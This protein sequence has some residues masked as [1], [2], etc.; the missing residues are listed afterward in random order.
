MSDSV[1][2]PARPQS[3]FASFLREPPVALEVIL[4]LLLVAVVVGIRLY[5]WHL[6]PAYMWSRDAGSY[7]FAAFQWLDTG[8]MVFDG[9]RG[10]VYTLLIA[11]ALKLFGTMNGVVWTQHAL[12]GLA[13][14]G[15]VATA[16]YCWGRVAVLPLF[17]C[18]ICLAAYGLPLH[19]GQLIRNESVL[20][21]LS[22]AAFCSWWL[23]L[24]RNSQTWLFI[25]ALSAGILT[26]TKNVFVPFPFALIAGAWFLEGHT[27]RGKIT[28]VILV[29]CGFAL[30]FIALRLD[31]EVSVHVNPPEPQSGI[32]FYGRTAQWTKLDGGIEPELKAKIRAEVEDYKARPKL[33]NNIVIKR[34]I[35]PHLWRE[36]QAQG[37]TAVDLD[38]LCRRLAI[39][40]VK[41]QPKAFWGQ[42]CADTY[43]LNVRG[44]KND[45]PSPEQVRDAIEELHHRDDD[46]RVHP[47]MQVEKNLAALE[48]HE[49]K[50]D[51]RLFHRLL[52]RALLFQ[53]YPVFETT[54]ALCFI[55]LCTR[56]REREFFLGGAAVWFFNMVLLCTV[57]RPIE[58]YLMPLVPVMFWALSGALVLLWRTAL[59]VKAEPVSIS[60]SSE[61]VAEAS[62]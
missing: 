20:F 9:R 50:N 33:D 27:L 16:R 51:F 52:S 60:V 21:I 23:A 62:R 37:K 43:K 24:K 59:R 11:G 56:G 34:T 42:M 31:N 46:Q 25:A 7:T 22:A 53:F 55:C 10:P 17:L 32:L 5:L 48:A 6:L 45:F 38:R 13:I 41:N 61:S 8:E 40:A 3:K 28:R 30:P 12:N 54:I 4:W 58:R 29:V 44:V 1:T 26:M 2:A 47:T 57:G 15:I 14:L 49:D 39:E 18:G 19:L 36:L 35:V